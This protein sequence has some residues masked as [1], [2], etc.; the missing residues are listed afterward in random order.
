MK[1][2]DL[3]GKMDYMI[4]PKKFQE[5]Y[6]NC[7][8]IV[9]NPEENLTGILTTLDVTEE[10]VLEAEKSKCNLIIAHHPIIFFAIKNIVE[11]N[12]N[13]K[14]VM[15]AITKGISIYAAHTSLDNRF[16]QG[17][18]YSLAT[19]LGL[20]EIH[21]LKK[22][23]SNIMGHEF[24][25]GSG[26]IGILENPQFVM[27]FLC[28]AK[29]KLKIE[30]SIRYSDIYKSRPISKIAICSGAGLFMAQDAKRQGAELFITS[31]INYHGFFDEKGISLADIGH[32]DSEKHSSE[33]IANILKESIPD[34]ICISISKVNT[35][36]IMNII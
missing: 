29:S 36:P 7:G 28:D 16:Q 11:S 9:G 13:Q 34:N 23:E 14:T 5:S 24:L 4:F 3:V 19:K 15:L 22:I 25:M 32:F 6:D 18:N 26:A 12:P 27:D 21:P 17:I 33:V 20:K 30:G 1:I 2:K 31:D 35:N 10:V 8:L